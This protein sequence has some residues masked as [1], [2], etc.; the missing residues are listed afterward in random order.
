[1]GVPTA[2][3]IP[4]LSGSGGGVI[5]FALEIDTRRHI[6]LINADGSGQ[7]QLTTGTGWDNWPSWSPDGT[8]I[9]FTCR[10]STPGM[11]GGIC[12][13]NLDGSGRQVLSAS[14]DWEPAWS[15]DGNWIAFASQRDG[16]PEI[17][18]MGAD[19]SHVRRLTNH[20]EE[21]WQPNWSPDGTKLAFTSGRD[22]DWEI[23]LMDMSDPKTATDSNL[24]QL[25]DNDVRDS[26]A[27]WSPDGL[28]IA[29]AS[30]RDGDDEIYIMPAP[31][32][33]NV[34]VGAPTQLTDNNIRDSFPRWSP[35]GAWI[36]F[37]SLVSRNK[38]SSH[39]LN[40]IKSDGSSQRQLTRDNMTQE[41]CPSWQP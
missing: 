5:A 19:G 12:V 28:Q 1:M 37:S 29:F 14:N 21:D 13:I 22:G 8:R 32:G 25:T 11:G 15:P 41:D 4:A 40:L 36:V 33:M 18:L 27:A 35:D 24:L 6:F 9:A 7:Q 26:H 16:N 23:Y 34:A 30:R 17:Y 2:T 10:A 39:D 20:P 31:D 3:P 38:I